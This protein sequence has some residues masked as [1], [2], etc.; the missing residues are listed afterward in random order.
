MVVDGLFD[1]EIR[2]FYHHELNDILD[3][4]K[5]IFRAPS[6]IK[7]FMSQKRH[8][9]IHVLYVG[10]KLVG[11]CFYT[12]SGTFSH[13]L[14]F[15]IKKGFRGMGLG[16]ILLSRVIE[17]LRKK[18]IETIQLEVDITNIPAIKLYKKFNFKVVRILKNYYSNG[19]DAYY[20]ILHLNQLKSSS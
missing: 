6:I 10:E 15:G 13:I 11:L 1:L 3:L 5:S 19:N 8:T 4:E 16:K 14:E 9:D 7:A 18:G 12:L 2:A 20:M 17:D